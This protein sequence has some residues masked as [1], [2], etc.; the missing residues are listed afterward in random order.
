M[1]G[2]DLPYAFL[3]L[4]NDHDRG[5]ALEEE[6]LTLQATWCELQAGERQGWRPSLIVSP[7]LVDWGRPMFISNLDLG[8]IFKRGFA[9]EFFLLFP[10]AREKFTLATAVRMSATFPLIS[11]A[12]RLPLPKRPRVV[13]AGYFDNFGIVA[14]ATF[15]RHDT[16]RT[17]IGHNDLDVVLI[18]IRA[19][20]NPSDREI[21]TDDS[22]T[23]RAQLWGRLVRA[24]EDWTSPLEGALAARETSGRFA[25]ELLLDDLKQSY[26]G[27]STTSSSSIPKTEVFPGTFSE[28]NWMR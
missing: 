7:Y 10:S 27:A 23:L 16:V 3:P 17:F 25:N 20:Q 12:V 6:W 28:K 2:N 18:R 8:G 15:L 19:F 22:G 14:A 11:P 9:E 13:D 21:K 24:F 4:R 26:P 1:I 5:K